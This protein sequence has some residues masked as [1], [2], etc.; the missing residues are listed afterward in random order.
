MLVGF[1]QGQPVKFELLPQPVHFIDDVL[2]AFGLV[3]V[4][5]QVLGSSRLRRPVPSKTVPLFNQAKVPFYRSGHRVVIGF[6][7][8]QIAWVQ[9]PFV[10]KHDPLTS[11]GLN[12]VGQRSTSSFKGLS[13]RLNFLCERR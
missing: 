5:Q 12:G 10:R 7:F 2:Q 4:A 1:Q 6:P 3:Q 9:V 11:P 8:H 13:Q